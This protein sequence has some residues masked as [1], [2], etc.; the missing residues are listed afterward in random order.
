VRDVCKSILLLLLLLLFGF[1]SGGM[2]MAV[3]LACFVSVLWFFALRWIV[4]YL[5]GYFFVEVVCVCV[6]GFVRFCVVRLDCGMRVCVC[7]GGVW[8]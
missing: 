2:G 4:F 6:C 3:L 1:R 8:L 7:G 5:F